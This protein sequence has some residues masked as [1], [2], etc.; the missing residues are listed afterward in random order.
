MPNSV[1]QIKFT[2]DSGIVSAFK[3]RC[4]AENVSMTSVISQCMK[5]SQPSK[6]A[7]KKTETRP[8]RRKA[9][10]EIID[11]LEEIMDREEAY[12]DDIPEQFETRRENADQ[13]CD[14]LA[15][16]ISCLEEAY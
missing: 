11:L 1:T 6:S 9:V 2:I 7:W 16:A 4:K 14:Q 3:A 5:T 12:R 10:L 15:Q 13:A 8:F